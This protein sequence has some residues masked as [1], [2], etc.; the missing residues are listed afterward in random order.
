MCLKSKVTFLKIKLPVSSSFSSN[1][2]ETH[3]Y[4]FIFWFV[5]NREEPIRT[6]QMSA[7]A[8]PFKIPEVPQASTELDKDARQ[9]EE[10]P[11]YC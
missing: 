8:S 3:L 1:V 4:L 11:G 7:M 10:P 6:A 5:C 2:C 9:N